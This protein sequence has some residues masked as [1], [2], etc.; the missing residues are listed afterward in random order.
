MIIWVEFQLALSQDE[1]TNIWLHCKFIVTKETHYYCRLL[2]ANYT[3]S[4]LAVNTTIL[5]IVA[6]GALA[7]AAVLAVLYHLAS[8]SQ[9]SG[10]YGYNYYQYYRN[11]RSEEAGKIFSSMLIRNLYEG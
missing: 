7:G 1:F 10:G 3:S 2:F 9:S 8:V 6:A 11:R 5:A 4:L